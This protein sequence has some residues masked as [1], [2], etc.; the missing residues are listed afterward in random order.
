M[1]PGGQPG[2]AGRE[3]R[4]RRGPATYVLAGLLVA[5]LLALI[6][7]VAWFVAIQIAAERHYQAAQ[8]AFRRRD[9]TTAQEHLARCLAVRRD[10]ADVHFLAARTARRAGLYDEAHR[11]LA[12]YNRLGGVPEAVELE[13]VLSRVQRGDLESFEGYLLSC[14]QHGHPDA[15]LLLE[16]LIKGYIRTYRMYQASHCL[17][18]LLELEPD[19]AQ[20]LIW[21][22]EVAERNRNHTDARADYRRAVELEPDNVEAR[23]KL[24]AVLF[25]HRLAAEAAEHYQHV[26][27]R[28]PGHVSARLGVTRCRRDLGQTE[29]AKQLL[30]ALLAENPANVRVLHERGQ[31]AL[32]TNDAADAEAWLRKA[33][34]LAPYDREVIYT[35]AQC[36]QMR[37]K[38]EEAKEYHKKREQ[39]EASLERL[40]NL[41]REIAGNPHDA[42]LRYEAG[43]IFLNN[44]Q[45]VEGLRWL[46]SA[47][48]ED[49]R[50]KP[51]HA[52]LAEYYQRQTR[53]DLALHHRR[54]ATSP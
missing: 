28:E 11:H 16:A 43:M 12:E 3:A 47:L 17:N 35:L 24:A 50:H 49:P 18:Q 10:S 33:V 15:A 36:L 26:L 7:G 8:D 23:L 22:G 40:S 30:D 4:P 39:I 20:A 13:Q 6:G 29:E 19:N 48:R 31:L 37:G 44:G 32:Q 45:D 27:L 52:A 9:F 34:S 25:H 54:L 42:G 5:G 14:V 53:L 38:H 41:T 46:E 1:K 2:V 21:R 51:T